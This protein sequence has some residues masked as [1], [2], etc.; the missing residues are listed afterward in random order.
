MLADPPV[1]LVNSGVL[2]DPSVLVDS[3]VNPGVLGDFLLTAESR[4]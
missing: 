3:G 2:V 1:V 4:V